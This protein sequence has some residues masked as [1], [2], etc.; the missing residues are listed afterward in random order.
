MAW[1]AP[2]LS[3]FISGPATVTIAPYLPIPSNNLDLVIIIIAL[4]WLIVTILSGLFC[5][6]MRLTWDKGSENITTKDLVISTFWFTLAQ[7][8]ITPFTVLGVFWLFLIIDQT[9]GF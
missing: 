9:I 2:G 8:F 7:V 4:S 5:S 3:A 6:N 1:L